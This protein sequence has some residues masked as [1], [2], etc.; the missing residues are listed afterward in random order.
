MNDL[1]TY[2]PHVQCDG[3]DCIIIPVSQIKHIEIETC[4][5]MLD[6]DFCTQEMTLTVVGRRKKNG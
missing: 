5:S 2:L 3:E 1:K 4:Q 6:Y